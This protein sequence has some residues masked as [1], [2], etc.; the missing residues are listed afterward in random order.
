ME[1]DHPAVLSLGL[2]PNS[3]KELGAGYATKG[4]ARGN[5]LLPIRDK[6]GTLLGYW[7][8][9]ELTYIPPQFQ[10]AENVIPMKKPA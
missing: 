3:M 9:E 1:S 10:L 7:G 5:V 6:H 4:V 2:N 8:V